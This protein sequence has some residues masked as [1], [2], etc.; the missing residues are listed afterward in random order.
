MEE[1]RQA[2]PPVER[3]RERR[4]SIPVQ[5]PLGAPTSRSVDTR[6][7]AAEQ[8]HGEAGSAALLSTSN[9][10]GVSPREKW[11]GESDDLAWTQHLEREVQGALRDLHVA[12]TLREVACRTTLCRVKLS[13]DSFDEARRFEAEAGTP[14]RRHDLRV[15]ASAGPGVSFELLLGR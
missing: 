6:L 5:P 1:V 11:A 12:G 3:A 7:P 9:D 8:T 2:A 10:D 4:A 14:E 13:F 15:E